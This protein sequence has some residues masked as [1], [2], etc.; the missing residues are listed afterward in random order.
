MNSIFKLLILAFLSISIVSCGDD[1]GIVLF[2]DGDNNDEETNTIVDIAA[3]DDQF[4]TLV[5]ALQR[6]NLVETL[7]GDGPFTVFAPTN[8]AFDAL[9]V[10]LMTISDDDL[11]EILLYHVLPSVALTENLAQGQSYLSTAAETGPDDNA[12]SLLVEIS[13]G[14][15]TVNNSSNVTTADVDADNGV[16]HIIDSVLTPLDV[17]GHAQANSS[18][19]SLVTAL[20]GASGELVS[21]LRG[22]GPFTV[23]AP[24]NSGF[25]AIADVTATLS[26]DQL[27]SVLTYHV[28]SGA[29]VLSS[30]LSDN[31]VVS[32]VNGQE[33]T[34][35]IG[36]N[37]QI[38]DAGGNLSD[39]I[40]T[41][42]QATNGVVH[43]ISN[44]LIPTL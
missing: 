41:D 44:V 19:S 5:S 39:V 26:P 23:F 21:V 34:V 7:Q 16:I 15:I 31:M 25:D 6:T 20:T 14:R 9:G 3:G 38:Q 32:T 11:T 4:S 27:G 2:P 1:D 28:I 42:V 29:N 43:A 36:D 22:D 33:F 8:D 17:V 10:D 35:L 37:V 13:G 24:V 12:L 18:F 30:D 40:I